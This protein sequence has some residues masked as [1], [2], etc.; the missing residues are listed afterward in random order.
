M[1]LLVLITD[2]VEKIILITLFGLSIWSFS[3]IIDRYRIMKLQKLNNNFLDL[4]SKIKNHQIKNLKFGSE[5]QF[6]QGVAKTLVEA[7]Q[8]PQ[9]V[10][11]AI[12]SYTKEERMNL[13]KGLAVLATLG[14]NAPFIGL[15]GTVLGIIRSFAY[16]G[17]QS[18]TASVMS[19][20]SQA[21]FA[22][23]FGLFV[24]IPAVVAFNIFT[25][26][27]KDLITEAE[28]LRDLYISEMQVDHGRK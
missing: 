20:I 5:S 1:E 14:S 12:S 26:M 16:L 11:A 15:F 3:I 8:Y 10:S 18:G 13:E 23:A 9:S 28:S 22:T 24:A 21:L 4:K 6:I 27:I 25:K 17:S 19:G 2:I 7:Q